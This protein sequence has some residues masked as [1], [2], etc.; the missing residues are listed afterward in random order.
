MKAAGL[1]S[2]RTTRVQKHAE[3]Q[4]NGPADVAQASDSKDPHT[5]PHIAPG[6]H[7]HST[8]VA[9]TC[10]FLKVAEQPGKPISELQVQQEKLSQK[11]G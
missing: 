4:G 2:T 11:E 7:V 1:S 8:G 3:A 10:I 6:M 9:E 5:E